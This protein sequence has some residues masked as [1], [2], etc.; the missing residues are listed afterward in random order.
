M[1]GKHNNEANWIPP[2]NNPLKK[3]NGMPNG[4]DWYLSKV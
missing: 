4:N 2:G 1:V 3:K